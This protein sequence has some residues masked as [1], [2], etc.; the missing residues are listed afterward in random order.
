MRICHGSKGGSMIYHIY[1]ENN[2][3]M[4]RVKSL[5]EAKYIISIRQGWYYKRTKQEKKQYEDAPF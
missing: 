2:E 4:R 1:D 3:L 5:T